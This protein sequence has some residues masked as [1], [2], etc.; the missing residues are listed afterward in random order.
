MKVYTK[1]GDKGTTSLVGG[2]RVAKTN[3]RLEAY[4]TVDEL[5]AHVALLRDS[6]VASERISES[7]ISQELSELLEVLRRLMVVSVALASDGTLAGKLP[8]IKQSDIELLEG[9]IDRMSAELPAI[10]HFTLPGGDP[11]ISLSHIAR[12]VCRRAE[13][14]AL[15][16]NETVT[17]DPN[18]LVYLNRLSD[19]LYVLGRH[20]TS[21]LEVEEIYWDGK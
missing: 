14:A 16:V 10:T 21:H 2:E 12:T 19:Y 7:V 20:L 13:R 6:I 18:A 4:G 1:T 17:V 9:G 15:R 5:A 3:I 11:L 8:V